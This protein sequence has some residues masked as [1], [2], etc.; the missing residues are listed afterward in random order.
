MFLIAFG[1]IYEKYL[2][3][4]AVIIHLCKLDG[5][6]SL[7]GIGRAFYGKTVLQIDRC[8]YILSFHQFMV[9]FVESAPES[10][11][12]IVVALSRAFP[13]ALNMASMM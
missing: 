9:P 7:F 3:Y 12:S 11:L 1:K 10:R 4:A 8:D 2:V 5:V 6:C 13:K